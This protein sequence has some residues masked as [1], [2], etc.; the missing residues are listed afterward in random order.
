MDWK[1][2]SGIERG[3]SGPKADTVFYGWDSNQLISYNF[4]ALVGPK[5]TIPDAPRPAH[6]FRLVFATMNGPG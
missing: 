5:N 4:L 3:R 1:K 6:L 2:S